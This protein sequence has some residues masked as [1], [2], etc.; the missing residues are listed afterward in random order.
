MDYLSLFLAGRILS[1]ESG[2]GKLLLSAGIGGV[3][4]VLS[5]F[6]PGVGFGALLFGF[7]VSLLMTAIVFGDSFSLFLRG[8]LLFYLIGFLSGGIL[9]VLCGLF[10]SITGKRRVLF[11][12]G[13]RQLEGELSLGLFTLFALLA[14]LLCTLF[15]RLF[16]KMPKKKN[17]EVSLSFRGKELCVNGFCDTGNLLFEPISGLPCLILPLAEAEKLLDRD[18]VKAIETGIFTG[19]EKGIRVI[20]SRGV[21]QRRLLFGFLPEKATVGGRAV[22]LCAAVDPDR[23]EGGRVLIPPSV[24]T[25][26]KKCRKRKGED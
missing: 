17:A 14:F 21:G 10:S 25:F 23:S 26:E 11:N 4:G 7:A 22:R 18:S 5:L 15:G 2:T 1:V 8:L 3:Y 19:G 16:S 12:G 9:T 13:V 6:L 20:P 24:M